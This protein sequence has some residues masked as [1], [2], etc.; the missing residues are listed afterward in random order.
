MAII[1]TT[2]QYS[3]ETNLYGCIANKACNSKNL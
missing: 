3:V 1:L 2:N